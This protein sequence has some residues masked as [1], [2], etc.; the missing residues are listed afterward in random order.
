ME[1]LRSTDLG[2]RILMRVAVEGPDGSL[3]TTQSVATEMAVSYPHAAKVVARLQKLGVVETRRGR[4]G[5]LVITEH[6]RTVSIG[7]LVRDLEGTAEVIECEG[8]NPCPLR[9]ACR[10][11]SVLRDAQEAFFAA[12]DP[13]TVGDL[14]SAPTGA[15]LLSLGRRPPD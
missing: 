5:G 10:L 14:T 8:V 12:L 15:V 2:L 13:Y 4:H 7:R 1:L 11:R 3:S 9:T 6:G